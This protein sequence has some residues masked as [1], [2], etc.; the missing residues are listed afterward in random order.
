M[1]VSKGLFYC[2]GE[3]PCKGYLRRTGFLLADS[4][5]GSRQESEL[6]SQVCPVSESREIDDGAQLCLL[7]VQSGSAPME[8][9]LVPLR[10]VLQL[11]QT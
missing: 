4:L 11:S 2:Y 8:C 7:S 6:A 10:C 1:L 5:R 3:T 9:C